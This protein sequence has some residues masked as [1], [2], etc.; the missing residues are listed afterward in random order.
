MTASTALAG[1]A[2]QEQ[3]HRELNVLKQ[4]MNERDA[5]VLLDANNW[6]RAYHDN[7]SGEGSGRDGADGRDGVDGRDGTDGV[8]GNDGIDGSSGLDGIN[9]LDGA[10][11]QKGDQG[12]QGVAG[13]AGS[14]GL[15]GLDGSLFD[16]S[17]LQHGIRSLDG[18][19]SALES[20]VGKLNKAVSGMTAMANLT[21]NDVSVA[22][23]SFQG[24]EALAVG[25]Q[26]TF[27]SG[28]KIKFSAAYSGDTA[29][30]A[31]V[32]FNW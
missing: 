32:G 26:R 14:D 5:N 7:H 19:T 27:D 15:D 20:Q 28:I 3:L 13:V 10:D 29:F 6:T 31:G 22:V 11:G 18:R 17:S 4:H 12:D 30:G 1:V 16:D 25:V 2:T 21:D 23:G 24:Y 8:D 9:G